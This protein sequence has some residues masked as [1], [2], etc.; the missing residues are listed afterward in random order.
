MG[1]F[2]SFYD[3]DGVEWQTKAFDCL[4]SRWEIGD[5]VPTAPIDHQ[6]KVLGGPESDPFQNSF[7]TLRG[8]RLACVPDVRDSSLPLLDYAG[9][10]IEVPDGVDVTAGRNP[11][12]DGYD[13][14][15]R[16]FES[17]FYGGPTK[18]MVRGWFVENRPA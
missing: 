17:N 15:V 1:M 6:V 8:G 7:A 3:A 11:F 10:W 5:A 9:G 4:L 14:A 18:D 12:L 13:T 2:D 16:V